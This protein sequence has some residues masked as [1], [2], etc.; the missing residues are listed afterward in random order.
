MISIFAIDPGGSTG[1]AWGTFDERSDTVK[2]A[3]T[4][5]IDSGSATVH[6]GRV[7]GT[8]DLPVIINRQTLDI[9]DLWEKFKKDYEGIVDTSYIVVEHFVLTP[10]Q[11]HKP[12]VEGIF[13]A[14]MIGAI[15]EC[16][17]GL[18]DIHLQTASAGLRF[19]DRKFHQMYGTWIAGKEHERAAWSHVAAHLHKILR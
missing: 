16:F 7:E 3:M 5:R 4:N 14:F 18:H 13:P 17:A 11:Y 12:G 19:N 8:D 2:H 15:C 1:V 9:W 6:R 10:R